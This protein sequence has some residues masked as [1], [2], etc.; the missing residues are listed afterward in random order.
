MPMVSHALSFAPDTVFLDADTPE[1]C[2]ALGGAYMEWY[3]EVYC[4]EAEE[5]SVTVIPEPIDFEAQTAEVIKLLAAVSVIGETEALAATNVAAIKLPFRVV[6]RDGMPLPVTMDY[7]PGRVN[8]HVANN[9]VVG[10]TVEGSTER[11]GFESVVSV[12]LPPVVEK[13]ALPV[14]SSPEPELLEEEFNNS[15]SLREATTTVVE[16]PMSSKQPWYLR[17]F[18]WLRF[19]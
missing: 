11:F 12:P 13:P 7:R 2:T 6:E 14:I 9:V 17:L 1:A 3:D 4:T 5:T 8:A 15:V 16:V 19:W 18:D 10:Y